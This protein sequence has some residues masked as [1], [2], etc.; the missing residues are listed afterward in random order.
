MISL[1]FILIISI[2]SGTAVNA[3]STAV[4]AVG[5]ETESN[6]T[7]PSSFDLTGTAWVTGAMSL[8]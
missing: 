7:L 5:E 4:T 2:V 3:V 6:V 1:L 8:P